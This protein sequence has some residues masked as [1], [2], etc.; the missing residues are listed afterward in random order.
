[1]RVSSSFSIFFF[2][3][4][5]NQL[6]EV[7]SGARLGQAKHHEGAAVLLTAWAFMQPR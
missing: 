1:M 3:Q 6:L 4:L 5:Q 2:F 7:F